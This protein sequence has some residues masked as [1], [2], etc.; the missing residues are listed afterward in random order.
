MRIPFALVVA[1]AMEF[2]PTQAFA[3]VIA[4]GMS[5]LIAR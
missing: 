1:T 4:V 5:R 2:V 3:L